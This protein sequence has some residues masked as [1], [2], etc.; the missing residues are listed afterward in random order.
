MPSRPSTH[1]V[2]VRARASTP[3]AT[4]IWIDLDNTPHVPF[5]LP[6]IR[7]LER[8]GHHVTVTVRDAFQVRSLADHH[9]LVY[10]SVGRHDG[11]NLLAKVLG[12]LWRAV[13]LLPAVVRDR[14]DVALSHGS[15]PLEFLSFVLRVPSMRLF[16]YEHST[17]WPLLKPTLGV[18]PD[19]LDTPEIRR[20]FA[21][22]LRT[23]RGLKE[24][25]YA[26]GF[27]PDGR[28]LQQLGVAA[29][30]VLVTVRPPATAAHYH[31]PDAEHL[32]EEVVNVL[33]HTAR[34]RMVILPRTTSPQGDL[35]RQRWPQWCDERR[36]IIPS[37]PLDGLNLVWHSD[38]VVSGGGTMN[39]EAAALGVPVYSIFRGTQGL[40]DQSL[41]QQG[42]LV[43][44]ETPAD[45]RTKLRIEKRH[46]SPVPS[47][48]D[49]T[50]LRQIL[51]AVREL[52]AISPPR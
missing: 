38:V 4:R 27:R 51:D 10:R 32:F 41:V 44:L 47:T 1:D 18:A 29:E 37:G 30:D 49:G 14:P 46:R 21:H 16:D 6:I 23:Y 36:I 42:R 28:I 52:I 3:G 9:G 15:R 12:T 7:A 33:G 2:E 48:P 17:E 45:V 20:W 50:A 19:A 26:S 34:V 39:R 8:E 35:V 11:A 43:L 5:F 25:V 24:D 40:V 31:N 13:Q 22:G